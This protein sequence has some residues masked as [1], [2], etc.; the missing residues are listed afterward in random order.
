MGNRQ[1]TFQFETKQG[2]YTLPQPTFT[3]FQTRDPV[4]DWAGFA[5]QV[6]SYAFLK[7]YR[8]AVSDLCNVD[9]LIIPRRLRRLTGL[10]RRSRINSIKFSETGYAVLSHRR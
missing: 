6:K 9:P 7:N 4:A 8:N 10:M 5:G 1:L 2:N 3:L